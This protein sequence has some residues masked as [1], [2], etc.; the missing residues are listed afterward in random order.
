MIW[1][2]FDLAWPWIGLAGAAGLLV[3]LLA[4]PWLRGP[5]AAGSRWRDPAW[6]AWL[7]VA[8]YLLHQVEEYGLDALGR[9]HAFPDALCNTLGQAPFPGCAIP[10][11]FFLA[12]NIPLIWI[13]GPAAATLA[14]WRPLAGMGVFGIASVNIVTHLALVVTGQGYAPGL[15][16][17]VLL[18]APL[19]AWIAHA[20]Y[21]PGRPFSRGDLALTLALGVAGHVALM[22][23]LQA[24]LHGLIGVAALVTVQIANAAAL[25]AILWWRAGRTRR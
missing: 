19:C 3:L 22:A 11:V 5:G 21:G 24:Y 7:S 20:C 2:G 17:A 12:V 15:A 13:S 10:P 14:R 23:S 8:A 9:A 4:T 6:L 1:S 16:T 25:P 18:V